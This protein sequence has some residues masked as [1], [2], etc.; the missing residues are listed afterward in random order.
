[1]TPTNPGHRV[2]VAGVGVSPVNPS[3][4]VATIEE[5]IR[6]DHRSYV[7]VT[8]AHG[9]VESLDDPHLRQIHNESGLTVPDGMP[10]VWSCRKAG[11]SDTSRVYG[12]DLVLDLGRRGAQQ[13][14]SFFLYG[15]K[16]GVAD[17]FARFLGSSF[18]GLVIAGTYCPPFR[19]LTSSEEAEVIDRINSSGADVVL[20]GLSTPKQERWMAEFRSR[21]EPAALI[22]V[23]A[24]FDFHTG[25]ARQAPEVLQRVGLE[26]LFRAVTEPRRLAGRYVRVVPRFAWHVLRRPPAPMPRTE[27][28]QT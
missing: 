27:V 23:G 22:G 11:F 16:E 10:L 17:E 6:S 15:G 1:M 9:I 2:D 28:T 21:L 12:P 3:I 8:G 20:V 7:C 4:A 19:A 18:P 24:A 14:W 5:W 13:A 25:N 26:W